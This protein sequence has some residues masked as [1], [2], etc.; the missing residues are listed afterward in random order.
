MT[1]EIQ[2]KINDLKRYLPH[3]EQEDLRVA[4]FEI[5][6]ELEKLIVEIKKPE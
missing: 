1:P 4:L 6:N 2:D 3:L 5:V